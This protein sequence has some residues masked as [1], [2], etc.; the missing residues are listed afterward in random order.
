VQDL[1]HKDMRGRVGGLHSLL[2][3][4]VGLPA[5]L[6]IGF[7]ADRFGEVADR[8]A[9]GGRSGRFRKAAVGTEE[10]RV[11]LCHSTPHQN[12]RVAAGVSAAGPASRTS[13]VAGEITQ[14][15]LLFPL[16]RCRS[17]SGRS[18]S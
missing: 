15:D 11:L 14:C 18:A 9:G 17:G 7:V 10:P 6:I 13:Y 1:T 3:E 16:T 8:R 5:S 12:G 4:G 2:L